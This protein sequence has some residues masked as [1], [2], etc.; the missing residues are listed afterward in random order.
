[1]RR[2]RNISMYRYL[3]LHENALTR[4][5]THTYTHTPYISENE[6]EREREENKRE[7]ERT[8]PCRFHL[9]LIH[10]HYSMELAREKRGRRKE[11]TKGRNG[12]S[13]RSATQ[14]AKELSAILFYLSRLPLDRVHRFLTLVFS[15][16]LR[17]A[18]GTPASP[19]MYRRQK[20]TEAARER[21]Q[22]GLKSSCA[23]R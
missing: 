4:T 19:S 14:A 2:D 8:S 16:L 18:A 17:R 20:G 15:P 23:P 1:M 13:E 9:Q 7:R 12:K 10:L 5:R 11:R 6:G 3:H 21:T 22:S